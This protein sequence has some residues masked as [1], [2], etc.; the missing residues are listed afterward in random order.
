MNPRILPKSTFRRVPWKNGLGFTSEIAI[1][2]GGDD[3]S[4]GEFLW[5]V[6][7]AKVESSSA[8]SLFENYDRVLV[9]IEG[10]EIDLVEK[11][12]GARAQLKP[13]EPHAFSGHLAIEGEL[14]NGPITDLNIFTRRGRAGAVVELLKPNQI[15]WLPK[16]KWNLLLAFRGRAEL[17]DESQQRFQISS[18]DALILERPT[19]DKDAPQFR[20]QT[21]SQETR[22]IA[23]SIHPV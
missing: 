3:F 16:A 19:H 23:I 10:D 8:F 18:G 1:Y 2:P 4:R 11:T 22:L 6:S 15:L 7:T 5:R 9:V 12:T 21:S 14:K 17:G 20:I 13:F